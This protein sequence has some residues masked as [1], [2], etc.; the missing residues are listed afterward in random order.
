MNNFERPHRDAHFV[1]TFPARDNEAAMTYMIDKAGPHL[2]TMPDG[3]TNRLDYVTD[4]VIGLRDHPAVHHVLP[5]LHPGMLRGFTDLPFYTLPD[6]SKLTA[7]SLMDPDGFHLGY[8]DEALASWEVFKTLKEAAVKKGKVRPDLK[9]QVGI[10]GD[11]QLPFM[12]FKASG[13][14]DSHRVPFMEATAE[15]MRKIHE[16]I[17]DDVVFQLELPSE[18]VLTAYTPRIKR[19]EVAMRF[20][21]NVRRLLLA[22]PEGAIVGVH[23][24]NIDMNNRS[25]LPFV[26]PHASVE[27]AN[28]LE[29]EWPDD[30]NPPMEHAHFPLARGGRAAHID[31]E[32]I[33]ELSRLKLR[34]DTRK[35]M[36]MSHD[37]QPYEEQER[38]LHDIER[39]LGIVVVS[40][41]CG[42]G[43]W[44]G[45]AT[46]YDPV[47]G[48]PVEYDLTRVNAN[49]GN[50]V[51]LAQSST[52]HLAA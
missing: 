12:A 29:E 34:K 49:V 44:R 21:K 9:F 3:E 7:E 15:E 2:A 31:Q 18:N 40:N 36:G 11:L 6:P 43:R 8:A 45:D 37:A 19:P 33:D 46:E 14:K 28:A 25:L 51:Q 30:H 13:F 41:T 16:V 47:T 35:I 23:L 17:G 38:G 5:R 42:Y 48:S 52:G 27:V 4:L 24:C 39:A 10:P 1:G 32:T 50:M 26:S 20:A 22:G